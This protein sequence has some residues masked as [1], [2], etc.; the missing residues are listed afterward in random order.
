MLKEAKIVMQSRMANKASEGSGTGRG[1]PPGPYRRTNARSLMRQRL[2]FEVEE[3]ANLVG[4]EV[5]RVAGLSWTVEVTVSRIFA[6]R[7]VPP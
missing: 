1:G 4:P 3:T 5:T 2:M 6:E 7:Y